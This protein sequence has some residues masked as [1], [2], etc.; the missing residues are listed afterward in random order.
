MEVANPSIV[1]DSQPTAVSLDDEILRA[2]QEIQNLSQRRATLTA[3]LL[4]SPSSQSLLSHAR[5]KPPASQHVASLEKRIDEYK[6]Q[7]TQ[8]TYRI[9]AGATMFESRDPDPN[10]VDGGRITGVRIEV[11]NQHT[12]TFNPPYYLLFNRPKSTSPSLCIHRH[13]IPPCIPLP[14]L[15]AKYFPSSPPTNQK[16][17]MSQNLPHL[18]R[19]LRRMLVSYHRRKEAVDKV[20]EELK[21]LGRGHDGD[22]VK[23]IEAADAEAK[24]LRIEWDSGVEGRVDIE[25]SGR[26]KRVVVVREDGKRWR[27]LEM[28]ILRAERIERVPEMLR[29]NS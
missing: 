20:S 28:R 16:R 19:E 12:R 25:R 21:H 18:V 9:C 4:T 26:L 14:T 17:P 27:D 5:A 22:K 1:P 29:E 3:A 8:N 13:T 2:R 10:A 15:A 6:R 7:N 24:S 23:N 11:Y